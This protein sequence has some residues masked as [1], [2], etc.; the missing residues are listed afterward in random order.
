ML[1]G[2]F[3]VKKDDHFSY[4]LPNKKP[5]LSVLS[6][7]PHMKPSEIYRN[8]LDSVCSHAEL[9]E[10]EV[11]KSKTEE[12]VNARSVLVCVLSDYLP[13]AQIATLI[14][15]THQCV[16]LIRRNFETKKS[17]WSVKNLFLAVKN[18]VSTTIQ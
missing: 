13:D 6:K 2:R 3:S 11:L 17:R 4:Y 18:D 15:R 16:N 1:Y 9:T 5:T 7:K 8:V 12:C 14:G 10:T